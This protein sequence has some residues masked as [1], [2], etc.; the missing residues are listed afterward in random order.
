[1]QEALD[2]GSNTTSV[3][4]DLTDPQPALAIEAVPNR[5]GLQ[6]VLDQLDEFTGLADMNAEARSNIHRR[7]VTV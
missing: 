2:T 1:M 5:R 6:S 3:P 7:C 4:N